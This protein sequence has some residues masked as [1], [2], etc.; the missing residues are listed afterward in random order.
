MS[1]DTDDSGSD[2]GLALV[3]SN[4]VCDSIRGM[5]LEERARLAVRIGAYVVACVHGDHHE[6]AH[7]S[8]EDMM[9]DQLDKDDDDGKGH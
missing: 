3:I 7:L 8:L 2:P 5:T 9:S 1:A 4:A 6:N